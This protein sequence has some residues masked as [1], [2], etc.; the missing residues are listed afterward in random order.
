[1][2]EPL[3]EEKCFSCWLTA[4][5]VTPQVAE[6]MLTAAFRVGWSEAMSAIGAPAGLL[7][8]ATIHPFRAAAIDRLTRDAMAEPPSPE[9]AAAMRG[10][11]H[12]G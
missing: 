10:H 6:A 11:S 12:G 1:M 2:S 5:G 4:L 7:R 8:P 3:H 9:V